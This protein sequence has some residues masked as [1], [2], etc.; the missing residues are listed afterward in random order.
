MGANVGGSGDG[1]TPRQPRVAEL[2]VHPIK[3][4]AAVSVPHADVIQTGLTGDRTWMW[5]DADHSFHSQR[6]LPQMAQISAVLTP[7][8]GVRIGAPH[9]QDLSVQSPGSDAERISLEVWGHPCTGLDAGDEAAAWFERATGQPGRLVR[10]TGRRPVD[11]RYA[12]DSEVAFEVAFADGFPLLVCTSEAI[13]EIA[14]RHGSTPDA[15]RFRPNLVIDGAPAFAEDGWASL[16]V[17]D[18]ELALVKPCGRCSILDVNPALGTHDRGLLAALRPD[19]HL[20]GELRFGMNAVVIR[21]GRLAV[22]DVAMPT[23]RSADTS[24]GSFRT[25]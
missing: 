5:I 3:S 17:G 7:D 10:H 11:A 6:T 25:I 22:G 20:G 21:G 8:G 4:C 12:P 9:M 2:W 18:V 19:R 1:E 13:A 23:V 15:R 14:A 24:L 16:R